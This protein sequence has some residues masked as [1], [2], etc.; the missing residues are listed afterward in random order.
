MAKPEQCS[1][2]TKP[3]TI[4][5][6]QIV[7][8]QINKVDLCE[9]CPYKQSA[10]DPEAFS[11]AD[12][13]LEPAAVLSTKD[14]AKC[15]Y[16]GFTPA[17]FKKSGR[18]GCPRCYES[19]RGILS[20]MLRG[21]HKGLQHTGKVPE[22]VLARISRKEEISTLRSQL[23]AAITAENYEEAAHLRDTLNAREA[24]QENEASVE[25]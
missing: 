9:D 15:D 5:L 1:H 6:T 3:A 13:L 4:H 19:F 7:N 20:P 22:R 17:D 16:C 2:C 21:M 11:L 25:K 12:F 23:Q 24:N 18:F 8:N 14:Q 10:T